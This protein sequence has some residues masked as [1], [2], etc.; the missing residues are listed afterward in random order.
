[1][2]ALV[3]S[4]VEPDSL[5]AGVDNVRD[6]GVSDFIDGSL[7]ESDFFLFQLRPNK[8]A[9]TC[10]KDER[11]EHNYHLGHCKF[12]PLRLSRFQCSTEEHHQVLGKVM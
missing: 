12:L 5:Q 10:G 3:H 6:G 2:K 4:G 9:F 11:T 8:L 1:M 7:Y